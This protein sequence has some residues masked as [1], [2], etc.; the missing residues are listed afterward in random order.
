MNSLRISFVFLA[1]AV[2]SGGM[3]A[4]LPEPWHGALRGLCI[5]ALVGFAVSFM[6]G[7]ARTLQHSE[8]TEAGM[9]TAVRSALRSAPGEPGK[10]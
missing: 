5:A 3:A 1:L 6:V 9:R 8:S 4:T 10:L 7:L 2:A